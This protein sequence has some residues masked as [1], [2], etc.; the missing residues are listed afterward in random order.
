MS[1]FRRRAVLLGVIGLLAILLVQVVSFVRASSCSW[2][3]QDHLYAGYMSWKTGDFG[4]NPEHPPMVKMVAAFP[5]LNMQLQRPALQNRE[6]KHEAFLGG[7]DFLFKN[8]ADAM[9]L[10]ARMA[11][12]TFTLLLALFVF[13]AGREMFG[14]VAGF[15]ALGLLVF[16]PNQVAHGAFVTTDTALTCFLFASVYTFYRYVKRPSI[17]RLV[18][19]GL[20]AGV[21]LSAKHTGVLVFPILLVLAICDYF[22]SRKGSASETEERRL[23]VLYYVGA[24][25]IVAV[26]ALAILWAFYGFRYAAR[27]AG[28][29]LNPPSAQYIAQLSRPNEAKVLTTMARFHLL[30][31]SYLYGLAD[32]RMT[33]DF[34]RSFVLGK[35]YPHGVWFYFPAAIVIKSTLAFLILVA[36]AIWA[37]ASRKLTRW[38]EILF[39]TV[40]VVLYLAV[41][42]SSPMNIGVR[43]I[44]PIYAFLGVLIG[45]AAVTLVKLH[46]RWAY[47]FAALI[48]FQVVTSL[49][50]FPDS[51]ISYVNEAWGGQKNAWWLLSDSNSDWAHQ[52]KATKRYLDAR[53]IKQ[54]W[55]VYFAEGVID[56]SYYGIPCKP[57]PT[58]DAMWVNEKFYDTPAM[59]DGTILISAANLS[60]FEFGPGEL[61]PYEQFKTIKPTSVIQNGVF[62]FDG[63]FEIPAAASIGHRQKAWDLLAQ[64]DPEQALV[65]AQSAVE[66][67]PNAVESDAVLGD[68]LIALNRN[69]EARSAYE[70]ALHSARTVH[71]EFQVGW[72]EGLRKKILDLGTPQIEAAQ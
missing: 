28:L 55:F 15:V 46:R 17:W 68:V 23:G 58:P 69:E 61:N 39:L 71:P 19:V 12:A 57:L 4:L 52:L 1:Q 48:L 5:I 11:V 2:D 49:R 3:E 50:A 63:H 16:N 7:K 6:F 72:V 9:L 45:G 21:A 29:Q 34:Y 60:G 30:P 64:G 54:C 24:L 56:T 8:D 20:V 53:G 22:L 38:R 44:L 47:V 25:A 67:S 70:R 14:T 35:T 36:I 42:M 32:V 13:L 33:G 59:I 18:L 37:I 41:A 51:Y 31:E 26:V 40:P 27:P 43:H 62:V 65:E 10:R 66:L